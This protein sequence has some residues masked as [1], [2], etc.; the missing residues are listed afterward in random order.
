MSAH[1]P[2]IRKLD[3]RLRGN[4]EALDSRELEVERSN[5][6]TLET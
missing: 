3:S 4:D 2:S 6:G 1:L 5:T